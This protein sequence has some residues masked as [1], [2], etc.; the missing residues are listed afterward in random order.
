VVDL[1]TARAMRKDR[2][3]S[4]LMWEQAADKHLATFFAGHARQTQD[5]EVV[6]SFF[7]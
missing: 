2:D 4:F 5:T 6:E 1:A 7:C 3:A